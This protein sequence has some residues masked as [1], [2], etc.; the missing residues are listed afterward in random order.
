MAAL[1]VVKSRL[2]RV[3]LGEFCLALHSAGAKPAAVIEALRKRE[4]RWPPHVFGRPRRCRRKPGRVKQELRTHIGTM[5][6]AAGPR[7]ETVH[8]LIGRLA[9]L[10]RV[11]PRLPS[12]LRARVT[13]FPNSVA[14]VATMEARERLEALETAA[15]APERPGWNPAASKF[16]SHS[17]TEPTCFRMSRKSLLVDLRQI[18]GA[19]AQLDV[20][21]PL[22]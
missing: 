4:K 22:I 14:A 13:E 6:E 10:A 7:G 1:D 18:A 17:S 16:K 9:E 20:G 15:A 3:G 5:H 12:V 2:D 8:A 19:S 21:R 11:L